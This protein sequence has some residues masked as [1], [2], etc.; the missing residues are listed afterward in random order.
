MA[1]LLS[2]AL[3]AVFYFFF[4]FAKHDPALSAVAPFGDDP[5]D[6]VGSFAAISAIFLVLIALVRAFRPYPSPPAEEREVYLVRTQMAIALAALITLAA[7]VVALARHT[8]LWLGTPLAGKLIALLGGMILCALAVAFVIRRTLRQ[9]ALPTRSRWTGAVAVS[10]GALLILAVYPE[11]L[12][13]TMSGHL[14]T[15][16]VGIL[17]LFAPLSTLDRALV[18]V[19]LEREKVARTRRQR[20]YP[21]MLALLFAVGVGVLVFLGE[22]REGGGGVPLARLATVFAVLVGVGA[23]GIVTGYAFLRKPLGLV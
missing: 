14:F 5:Y 2:A 20:A 12:I 23:V 22:T 8:S 9:I 3:A 1:T 21:W 7:D 4:M 13:Q 6:A 15:I 17:L 18:P 11:G 19:A 10:L 16:F